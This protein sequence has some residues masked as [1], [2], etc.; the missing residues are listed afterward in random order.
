MRNNAIDLVSRHLD[1]EIALSEY[2][3]IQFFIVLLLI[4]LLT[5]SF[6][7]FIIKGTTQFFH[8]PNTKFLVTGWFVVFICYELV[9]YYIARYYLAIKTVIPP[10]LKLA[11]VFT[12]AL[13]P[14]LLLFLLCYK[15]QSVIFLDSP[16]MFFYFVLIV[17]SSL[18]LEIKLGLITGLVSSLGY[19]IITLWS[20]SEFDPNNQVL[21]FP[22]ILYV[23]RSFFMF[24]TAMGSIFVAREIKQRVIKVFNLIEKN[25]KLNLLFR[26]QVSSTV[27]DTLLKKTES[28]KMKQLSVMFLDIRNFS[29]YAEAKDP[30][31]INEFQNNFFGPILGIITKYHGTTNQILGDGLMATFESTSKNEN[32]SENA[33]NACR[34]LLSTIK[35]LSVN[36]II[37]DIKVGIG[38]HTGKV[39]MAN[40]GNASRKQFSI[41]G[42]AVIIAARLEQLNKEFN[43]QILVSKEFFQNLPSS[44]GNFENIG[45]ISVKNISKKV[46]VYKAA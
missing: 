25:S 40:I 36:N 3:R 19:L 29:G 14:S 38:I 12:E 23:A 9:G 8:N 37:P 1:K 27:A 22:V 15:E 35:S 2:K 34:E 18:N 42:T 16:V 24:L 10:F 44:F 5:M 26:Q 17:I 31:E 32:H 11:N 45:A 21:H 7:F 39:V 30:K 28:F 6:N 4:G 33:L 43:T 20:I 13:F 46:E 41:S